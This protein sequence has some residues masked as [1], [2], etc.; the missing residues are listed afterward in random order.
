MTLN[1]KEKSDIGSILY[2]LY[3]ESDWKL[4]ISEFYP[5]VDF[6][7]YEQFFRNIHWDNDGTESQ[8]MQVFSELFE[9]DSSKVI[10]HI[11]KKYSFKRRLHEKN[12]TL[13]DKIFE[14][15]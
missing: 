1:T 6:S 8:C 4:L 11:R 5:N 15:Y 7:E 2:S 3:E 9:H 14:E 12:K 10:S 13:H